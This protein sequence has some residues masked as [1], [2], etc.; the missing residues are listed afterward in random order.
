MKQSF[1]VGVILSSLII[2]FSFLTCKKEEKQQA[3]LKVKMVDLPIDCDSVNV[4]IVN[5]SVH[6]SDSSSSGWTN[7]ATNAGMYNLLELQNGVT[8]AITDGGSIP[9]GKITQMRLLL[10]DNN[11]V[12]V[13]ST[14]HPLKLSSQDKTG[15]KININTQIEAQDS[16]E[17]TIDFDAE[18]S[19][20][21]TGNN[22]YKLKP[23]VKL[24]EVIFF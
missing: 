19:I 13:D 9:A 22:T 12:V 2:C 7:L 18:K 23:V 11:Y 21:L 6:Y 3:Y 15:L 24:E 1:K 5:V 4:E 17:I 14:A 20:L 16:V 8:A 10:G